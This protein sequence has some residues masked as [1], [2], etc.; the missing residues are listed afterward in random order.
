MISEISG[1]KIVFRHLIDQDNTFNNLEYIMSNGRMVSEQCIRKDGKEQ[2]FT[3]GVRGQN[4]PPN[5]E[6]L[7]KL[8]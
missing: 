5:S 1:W 4:V 6:V 3:K 8:S 2:W 7:T